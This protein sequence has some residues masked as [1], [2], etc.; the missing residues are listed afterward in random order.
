[1]LGKVSLVGILAFKERLLAL[2]KALFNRISTEYLVG[3]LAL[4]DRFNEHENASFTFAT[5]SSVST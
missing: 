5:N 2:V 3:M 1:M 4:T